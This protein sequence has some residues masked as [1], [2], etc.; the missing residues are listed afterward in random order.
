MDTL[1]AL[2]A[3]FTEVPAAPA[4][5][6]AAMVAPVLADIPIWVAPCITEAV[7]TADPLWAYPPSRPWVAVC[8]ITGR[9]VIADAAAVCS[10]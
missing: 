10:R 7:C 2:V 6:E 5:F 1:E 4:V 9:P 8:G 3:D